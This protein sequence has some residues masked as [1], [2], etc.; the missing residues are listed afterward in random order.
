[1]S[2]KKQSTLV[3]NNKQSNI[4][5]NNKQSKHDMLKSNGLMILLR[6]IRVFELKS[7]YERIKFFILSYLRKQPIQARGNKIPL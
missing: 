1:M 5:A 6:D 2:N 7:Y 4:V 3:S